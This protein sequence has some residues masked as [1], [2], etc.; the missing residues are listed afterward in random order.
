MPLEPAIGGETLA[1]P[2]PIACE[3]SLGCRVAM[4]VLQVALQVV[5]SWKRLVA[6]GLGADERSLLVVTSHVRLE[7]TWSVEA[8][9]AGWTHIVPSAA[10][11]A[12][13]P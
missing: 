1:T 3:R 7:A 2:I 11:L 5:F 13:S 4:G 9:R 12:L 6:A 10:S 8:L